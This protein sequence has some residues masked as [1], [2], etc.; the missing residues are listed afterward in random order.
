M[1]A[2]SLIIA[3]V[4]LVRIVGARIAEHSNEH[5]LKKRGGQVV[6]EL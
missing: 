6:E 5:K 3:P 2:E 4:S 1:T